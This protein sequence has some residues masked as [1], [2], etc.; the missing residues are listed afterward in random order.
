MFV[1]FNRNKDIGPLL[2]RLFTGIRLIYG[3]QDNIFSWGHMKK[4]AVFL[5]QYNFPFPLFCAI[6]SVYAQAIAGLAFILGWKT[7]WAAVLMII[8]LVSH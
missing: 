2:L 7:R 4:F 8:I 5:G 3:V 6:V 1:W